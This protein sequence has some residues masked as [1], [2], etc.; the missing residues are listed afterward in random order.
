MGGSTLPGPDDLVHVDGRG[1]YCPAGDFHIDPWK[2]VPRAVITHAHADHA[3]PDMD[4]YLATEASVPILRRRLHEGADI[5]GV[6]FGE[7]LCLGAAT[8]SF[9]P[10]G[11]VLGSAQVRVEMAGEVWV[12][13]GDYKVTPDPSCRPFE[14]VPCDVFITEAT[15]A[16]PIYTWPDSERVLDQVAAWWDGNR[17]AGRTSVVF[18]YAL[19]KSQ[20]LLAGLAQRVDRPVHLHGALVAITEIYREAGVALPKVIPVADLEPGADVSEALVIAPPSAR[21]TSWMRRFRKPA[22]ALASGW[23]QVRGGRRRR[24]VDRGFVLSDHADWNGLLQTI[25]ATGA[26][27]VLTTHGAADTLARYLVEERGLDAAP[28]ETRFFG[29]P[30]GD[31]AAAAE[32]NA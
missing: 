2:P 9:H 15:F 18:S 26:R 12:I 4:S 11:H 3:R 27:R 29:E 19:G 21:G 8:V 22:T 31:D 5:R 20:R 23:M 13:S 17:A 32:R 10:A 14:L 6:P 7:Q 16:L 24:N 30:E 28:L 1:L 25:E